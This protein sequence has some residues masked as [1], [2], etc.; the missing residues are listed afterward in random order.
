MSEISA[1]GTKDKFKKKADLKPITFDK[2]TSAE[3]ALE[4]YKKYA[5]SKGLKL[6]LRTEVAI[7]IVLKIFEVHG[8]Q[9][10][11]IELLEE[12][13]NLRKGPYLSKDL[14]KVLTRT[15]GKLV[16]AGIVVK[17]KDSYYRLAYNPHAVK[18]NDVPLTIP[19]DIQRIATKLK[20]F[21]DIAL[22][23]G[24]SELIEILRVCLLRMRFAMENL[25]LQS[26]DEN[27]YK[28]FEE[29]LSLIDDLEEVY[30]EFAKGKKVGIEESWIFANL[31]KHL[32]EIIR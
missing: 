15:L 26:N 24:W 1:T 28:T 29:T 21:R 12:M 2:P 14:N 4:K 18:R 7:L 8:R 3:E 17:T 11:R 20:V 10:R 31:I 5:H 13:K 23:K 9:M 25:Q 32:D 27:K 30:E 16:Q 19:N 22:E 6:Q